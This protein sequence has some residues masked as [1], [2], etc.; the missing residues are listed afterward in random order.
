MFPQNPTDE[1]SRGVQAEKFLNSS[2]WLA[3]PEFLKKPMECWPVQSHGLTDL[4]D[5]FP[6][7]EK[8][9]K[10][11]TALLST[12]EDPLEYTPTDK[13]V[14]S[15]SSLYRLKRVLA[16]LC[17]F[18]ELLKSRQ[19]KREDDRAREEIKKTITVQ[20]LKQVELAVLKYTQRKHFAQLFDK[21][22][23]GRTLTSSIF[24]KSIKRLNPCI[25]KVVLRVGE[26]LK[27]APIAHEARHPALLPADS[28]SIQLVIGFFHEQAGHGG[29]L[30]TFCLLKQR[31]WLQGGSSTIGRV[32]E[33]CAVCKRQSA[34][35]SQQIMAAI[36]DARMQI[37]KPP[38]FLTGVDCFG[39]LFVKQGRSR[40]KR[41]GCIF[42]CMTTR[43]VHL[44]VLHSFSS[45]SFISALRRFIARRGSIGHL[46]YDNGINFVGR[47]KVINEAIRQWNQRLV[48]SFLLQKEIE[49]HFNAPLASHFGG[50]WVRLIS[51]VR[52]VLDSISTETTFSEEG[53]ATL[54]VEVEGIVNSRPLTPLS[55]V[56]G[57]DKPLT[58]KDLLMI[59]PDSGLPPV[60]SSSTDAY[61]VNRWRHVQHFAD[62]FW[63]RWSK[64]YLP[65]LKYCKEWLKPRRNICVNDI[66]Y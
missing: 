55:F 17:K 11:I 21:I 34:H 58:P 9:R 15:F 32:L 42:S 37:D 44:E 26:R 20:E 31:Y 7:F 52:K 57:L 16:W 10:Q 2:K 4:P 66:V 65:T 27:H 53:L 49:W 60:D 38:F 22:R 24:P 43:A 63:K 47:N 54:F 3:G 28:A 18:S 29:L 25:R 61:F 45:D 40:V 5:E 62:V 50:S 35:A 8:T 51:S 46:H 14:S 33:K 39:P 36:P 12:H 56:D 13:F 19:R 23:L 6:L 30:H 48:S 64:E 41:Y 59:C 1:A